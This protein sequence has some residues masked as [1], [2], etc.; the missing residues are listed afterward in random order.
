MFAD[1]IEL[2]IALK[3][4]LKADRTRFCAYSLY[5]Y[6]FPFLIV[7]LSLSLSNNV[8]THRDQQWVSIKIKQSEKWSSVEFF[9]CWLSPNDG[10]IW[11]FAIPLLLLITINLSFVLFY[12]FTSCRT[13]SNSIE[14]KRIRF[15]HVRQILTVFNRLVIDRHYEIKVSSRYFSVRLGSS[16]CSSVNNNRNI[17]RYSHWSTV[18]KA[19]FFFSFSV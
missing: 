19:F 12:F 9:S 4:S 3:Y 7:V 1:G 2:I 17:H 14:L 13:T 10:F 5:A 16:A 18:A 6:G 11:A 15:D 8:Q